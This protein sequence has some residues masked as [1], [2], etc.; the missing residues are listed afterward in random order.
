MTYEN[1]F[2]NMEKKEKIKAA[3]ESAANMISNN[4]G[5]RKSE[6]DKKIIDAASMGV[7][8]GSAIKNRRKKK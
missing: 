2:R 8:M 6:R 3:T 1:P 4:A 5:G 7:A